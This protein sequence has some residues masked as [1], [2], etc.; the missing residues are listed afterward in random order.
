MGEGIIRC[1]V[2]GYG[3][4]FNMGK[5]HATWM[6]DTGRMSTIAACDLD[7]ARTEEAKKDLPGITVYNDFDQMLI[8]KD[9][10]L[11]VIITPHNT[12]APLALKALNAGKHVVLEK[13]MCITVDEATSMIDAAKKA[14]VTLTTFHNRRH[15]GDFMAIKEVIEKGI[16]GDV[17]HIEAF[18]GGYSHPG[19]WWRANKE[20]SGGCMYDWG[21][22]FIDWI[23]NLIPEEMESV[24]GFFHKRVWM[25]V[26]NEDQTEAIIKFKNGAV[27]NLQVSSIARISKPK[28]RILGTKGAITDNWIGSFKLATQVDGIPVDGDVKYKDSNW[29]AYYLNLAAHLLDGAPLEVTPESSRRVIAVIETAEKS[30]KSGKTEPVPFK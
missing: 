14:G 1:A 24:T 15:D 20:I 26:T 22:H 9:I 4:A 7:P 28:W 19:T 16:I 10:D 21:A 27:A 12:H 23:L 17:F 2:V 3:G 13:P 8:N 5:A 11:V 6:N 25:D 29:P 18:I 30:A